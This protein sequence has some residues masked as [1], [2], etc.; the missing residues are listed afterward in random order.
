TI[1]GGL[2]QYLT[3]VKIIKLYVFVNPLQIKMSDRRP[4]RIRKPVNYSGFEDTSDDDFANNTP[5]PSKKPKAEVRDTKSKISKSSPKA[6]QKESL[7]SSNISTP[8]LDSGKKRRLPVSEKIYERELKEAL[9]ISLYETGGSQDVVVHIE[10]CGSS[11]STQEEN[12]KA[13]NC[14]DVQEAFAPRKKLSEQEPE[15]KTRTRL[16][17]DS[18]TT[19]FTGIVGTVMDD[20]IEVLGS[21][22]DNDNSRLHSIAQVTPA[23]RRSQKKKQKSD[24]ES[25]D[26]SDLDLDHESED[27]ENS[28]R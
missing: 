2:L 15:K 24:D 1:N 21:L 13:S 18:G 7:S 20:S 4:S 22:V 17:H 3:K 26:S 28:S 16:K 12:L 9:Q 25:E 19:T 11:S 23:T 8:I 6:G 14:D 27:D 10:D 5:P